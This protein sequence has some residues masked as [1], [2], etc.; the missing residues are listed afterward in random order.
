MNDEVRVV[1][2]TVSGSGESAD[3]VERVDAQAS[4]SQPTKRR[5]VLSDKQLAALSKGREKRW[6]QRQQQQQK[7]QVNVEEENED[8]DGIPDPPQLKR[9]SKSQYVDNN[10][11]TSEDS[12]PSPPRPEPEQWSSSEEEDEE[13]KLKLRQRE[14]RKSIP[15]SIRKQ[16]DMYVDQKLEESKQ[17]K[18]L[19]HP[20][21]ARD[22]SFGR[23]SFTPL[24]M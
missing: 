18:Y 19:P 23:N 5:R 7:T 2:S 17:N 15:R 1:G 4:V 12:E 16:I 13:F 20:F 11:Y 10:D 3:D 9:E 21:S 22:S 8:D 14:V 24:Y 6:L